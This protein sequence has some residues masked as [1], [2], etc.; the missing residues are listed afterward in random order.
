MKSV[1]CRLCHKYPAILGSHVISKFV[2]DAIKRNS[3]TGYLRNPN[4]INKRIQDGDKLSLLC[5][6]CE[7]KFGQ[8]EKE[9]CEQVFKPFQEDRLKTLTYGPWLTYFI[10]SVS[11]RALILDLDGYEKDSGL[12]DDDLQP[13]RD[14]EQSMRSYLLG[15]QSNLDAIENYMMI[16]LD[17]ITSNSPD[18]DNPNMMLRTSA[19]AYSCIIPSKGLYYVSGNLAGIIFCTV[20]RDSPSSQYKGTRIEINQGQMEASDQ[21]ISNPAMHDLIEALGEASK[22]KASDKQSAR[23]T[24]A[25]QKNP[26]AMESKSVEFAKADQAIMDDRLD[27]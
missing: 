19:L 27:K 18:L 12:N 13:V 9:F 6:E 17:R 22:N 15:S 21:L 8:R 23:I 24:E 2:F 7:A 11:W 16:G 14:A 3:P 25:F 26:N 10:V 20:I 5:T 1:M 4:N